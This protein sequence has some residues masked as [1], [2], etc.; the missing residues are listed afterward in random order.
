MIFHNNSKNQFQKINF[1]N[2]GKMLA[3][4]YKETR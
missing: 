4:K 2:Y 3:N 1:D